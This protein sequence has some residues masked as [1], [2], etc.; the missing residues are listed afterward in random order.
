MFLVGMIIVSGRLKMSPPRFTMCVQYHFWVGFGPA[1][2]GGG[3]VVVK[4][5]SEPS[6]K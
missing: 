2:G 4:E 1:G 5:G 3:V 6:S